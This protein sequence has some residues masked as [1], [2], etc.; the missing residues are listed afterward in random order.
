[1]SF[2]GYEAVIGLEIHAQLKTNSKIFCSDSTRFDA[3]DNE[4]TSH[5]SW[6]QGSA[7]SAN[8]QLVP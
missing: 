3:A 1:M 2:K 4:N 8:P 6:A 7:M 5:S